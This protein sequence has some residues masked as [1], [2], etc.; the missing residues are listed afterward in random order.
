M[1]VIEKEKLADY[2]DVFCERGYFSEEETIKI[3]EA[4]IKHGMKPKVHANQMRK[5]GGVQAGVQCNAISVDHLKLV[6]NVE[7][8]LLLKS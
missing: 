7:L 8:D 2:C 5:S 4:G 6:E 1:P 3:L